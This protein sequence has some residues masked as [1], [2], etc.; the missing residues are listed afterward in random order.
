MI[1][2]AEKGGG[3]IVPE[4]HEGVKVLLTMSVGAVSLISLFD[5]RLT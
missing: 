3:V 4:D 2:R 5:A 1:P